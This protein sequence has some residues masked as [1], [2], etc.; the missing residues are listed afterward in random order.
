MQLDEFIPKVQEWASVR[1]IYKQSTEEKQ[2]DKFKE[3]MWEYLTADN[4]DETMDGIGDMAV[5]IVNAYTIACNN[6]K[7]VFMRN[8]F[9]LFLYDGV[10]GSMRGLCTSLDKGDY[11]R[12]IKEL[13]V[14]SINDDLDFDDCLQMAWD[15]IK[16][17]KGLMVDGL[18]VKWDNLNEAQR[19]EL[20]ANLEAHIESNC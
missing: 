9:E 15:E 2:I 11:D 20:N 10:S 12:A 7:D 5:T 3:K 8:N 4:V 14:I 17:R 18:Y 13:F 16:D 1:G 19:D 6:H